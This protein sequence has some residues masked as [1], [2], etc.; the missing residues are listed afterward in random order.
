MTVKGGARVESS[1]QSALDWSTGGSM[2]EVRGADR[3]LIAK[4]MHLPS[5]F[6]LHNVSCVLSIF[7]FYFDM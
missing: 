4:K 1:R 7:Y 2:C 6:F 5:S 3:L